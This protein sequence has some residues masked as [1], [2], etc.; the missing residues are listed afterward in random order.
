MSAAPATRE[1]RRA[2]VAVHYTRIGESPLKLSL[3]DAD[4]AYV[5][6]ASKASV[7]LRRATSRSFVRRALAQE[8]DMREGAIDI[9]RGHHGRPH[10]PGRGDVDFSVSNTA[11]LVAVAI[12]REGRI[13]LDIEPENRLASTSGSPLSLRIWTLGEA[14]LKEIGAGLGAPLDARQILRACVKGGF[15][16]FRHAGHFWAVVGR[17]RLSRGSVT[18]YR[19]TKGA[20]RRMREERLSPWVEPQGMRSTGRGWR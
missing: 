10:L 14:Y 2:G 13:G 19:W 9:A 15:A 5:A 17:S 1:A 4:R 3:D 7:A 12:S 20:P 6:E 8:L 18:V 11:T 16:S